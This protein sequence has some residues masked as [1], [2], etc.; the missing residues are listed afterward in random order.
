[1]EQL[2]LIHLSSAGSIPPTPT[3]N[4]IIL[5]KRRMDATIDAINIYT[6]RKKLLYELKQGIHHLYNYQTMHSFLTIEEFIV[7]N[8][9]F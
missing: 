4:K 5:S 1:M 2:H 3:P 9:K 7:I 8:R 6:L